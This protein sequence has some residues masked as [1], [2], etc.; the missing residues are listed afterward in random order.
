MLLGAPG[1]AGGNP[2]LYDG[3]VSWDASTVAGARA[4]LR[5]RFEAEEDARRER[6]DALRDAARRCARV[7][8]ERFGVRRVLLFGSVA[9]GHAGPRSDL[10]LAVEGLDPR[11]YFEAL[12]QLALVTPFDVDLVLLEEAPDSLRERIAAYGACLHGQ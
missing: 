2:R 5:R 4:H 9:D 1:V 10:D 8:V 6:L 11:H 12:G 7:L 3:H